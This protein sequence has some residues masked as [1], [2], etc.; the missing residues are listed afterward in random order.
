MVGP[1]AG[2]SVGNTIMRLNRRLFL[3]GL[4]GAAVAAPFLGSVVE[5]AAK[6]E[7][8]GGN[9]APKRLIVTFTN[10]GCLTTR[11]FPASSHGPLTADD[12]M[13]TS[14]EVLAPHASK[15]LVPRG[16]RAMNEWTTDLSLGQGND[17]H[18]QVV[19]SY[20]TCVP[21]TPHTDDPFDFREE[22]K[23]KAMPTAPSLDHVCAKQLHADGVPLFLRVGGVND[24]PASA[25]SY[26]SDQ[27]PFAGIGS[28]VEAFGTLTGL[29]Q[30]GTLSSRDEYELVRGKSVVDIVKSDL[31]T[32][33]RFDMSASDRR[34][35]EAWKQLLHET[36]GIVGSA[37]CNEERAHMLGLT[38][39]S[40]AAIPS[41]GDR[42][43]SMV[44]DTLDG[45]DIFSNIA[46]LASLCDASRVT[47]LKFP[48]NYVYSGLGL[49]SEIDTLNHRVGSPQLSGTCAPG[50]NEM[51]LT[52]DRY[53]AAKFAHLVG[54][55]DTFD[56]GD[57][58]LLD[59]CAV[60][61]F[62]EHSDGCA[63]NLNNM[64]ILQAGSCG[65]YFKTGQAVNVDDGS[66]NL[67]R[68]NSEAPCAEGGSIPFDNFKITGTPPEI[69]NAPIN[70]YY[71]NLM[72]AIGVKAGPDGFPSVGGTEAVTHYGMYDRTQDFASGGAL[73]PIISDPGEFEELKGTRA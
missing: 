58:T 42:M 34:K 22:V 4:G 21:I 2:I 7:G 12:Y 15:L 61:W 71:C 37:Q 47:F 35:L 20:F 30:E 11:W 63:M 23:F 18:T 39:A 73:P 55:L 1:V 33:E 8:A 36:G 66:S 68:G 5:R 69:A 16:I 52:L 9:V 41:V 29:F 59:N 48:A 70:K 17:G 56:E 44:T 72:N 13:G 24:T 50:V 27:T 53:Y 3:R 46:V 26:S 49:T 31:E 28:A 25:I 67:H 57:G 51:L 40:V 10:N 19:G 32:L 14:L 64:P 6:A 38:E 45:A 60:V 43:S 62:R 54:Q 65:G